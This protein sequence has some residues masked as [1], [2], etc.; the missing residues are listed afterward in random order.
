MDSSLG[1]LTSPALDELRSAVDLLMPKLA[2][3]AL[4]LNDRVVTSDPRFFQGSAILDEAY[5]VK[6]AWSE[7]PARRI[8]REGHVLA[9]LAAARGNLAVPPLVAAG[10]NPALLVTELVRGESLSWEG[11]SQASGE[12]R[13]RLVEGL[14]D[15]LAVLHDEVTLAEIKEAGIELEVPEPQATTNEI[16]KRLSK[17]VNRSRLFLVNQWCDWV[18][19][20]LVD[21]PDTSLLHGDLHGYNL[22]W[23]PLSG[24]LLLV[25]DFESSGPGDPAFDFRY[26]PSQAE[27]VD[28]FR[29]VA[30]RYERLRGRELNLRRVMAW[31]IRTVLG[32]AL[33]RTEANVPLPGSGGTPSSWVDELQIRLRSVLDR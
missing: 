31:H 17:F 19:E 33:W 30:H 4:V 11:A 8:V 2:G 28:L 20:I 26:L 5:V 22:V 18:D 21:Q 12:P 27:T 24:S 14:A 1:W 15:F 29:E 6:F 13:L 9:A 3:R 32:D 23:D 16:R 7:P 25:A 10:T